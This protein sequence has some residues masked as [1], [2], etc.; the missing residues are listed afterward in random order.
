MFAY[1]INRDKIAKIIGW[2]YT[3]LE[4]KFGQKIDGFQIISLMLAV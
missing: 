1:L 4:I 3:I 2:G